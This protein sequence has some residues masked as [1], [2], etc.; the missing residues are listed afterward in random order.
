MKDEPTLLGYVGQVTGATVSVRLIESVSSGMAIIKGR[1]YRI[2]QVGSFVRIPQGYQDLFGVVSQVGVS[3]VPEAIRALEPHGARWLTVELIGES[4]G[5]SFERGISQ[6]PVVNDEVHLVTE[7]D[8]QKIYG[9][10]DSGQIAVGH[11]AS[12]E[13][14][15]VRLDLDKLVTRH[16]A[17]LGSTGSGKSTTVAS[18]LRAI[19]EGK[20]GEADSAYPSARILL[21]DI[22]GEYAKALGDVAKVFR[23]NADRGEENLYIPYWALAYDDLIDF[24]TGG[25]AE[26]KAMHFRDKIVALK[27]EFVNKW[28]LPGIDPHSLTVD[29][30]VPFSLKRLWYDLIDQDLLTLKGAQRDQPAL[31]EKGDADSLVPPKYEPWA[32]GSK[33]VLNPTA[34]GVRRQLEHLRSRLLDHRFDFLL[35]PGDWEPNLEGKVSKDLDALLSNWLGHGRTVTILDLSGIPSPVMNRLIAAVLRVVYEALFWSRDKSEGGVNRPLLIVMEEAHAFLYSARQGQTDEPAVKVARRIVKEGRKYGIGAMVVS[36]RPSEVDETILSQCGTFVAMRLSNP[37]DRSRVQG[38]LPDNLAG[39]TDMLPVLRTGE[40]VITGE[41]AR[42]PM[43]ARI[44]LPPEGKRPKSEDP[45]VSE[46]WA[47]A[48]LAEDYGQVAAAWRAQSPR[49]VKVELKIPRR[50]IPPEEA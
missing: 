26:D 17:V 9:A 18:L 28:P 34:P 33:V 5:S 6:H 31:L 39:L 44:S 22:H 43:R 20:E 40:A 13:S 38:T 1:T 21:L 7:A 10:A 35:H 37:L 15:E 50:D 12:A 30:P 42:L 24:L 47:C 29:V 41:A 11:L 8:L 48:R 16:S 27:T 2:G 49:K 36:Q 3:A 23:I 32:A 14:I 45:N 4:I 25:I 46:R 19:S